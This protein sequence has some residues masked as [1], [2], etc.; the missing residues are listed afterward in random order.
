[1]NKLILKVLILLCLVLWPR[2]SLKALEPG[3]LLYRTTDNGKMYGYS[4][5]S[6]L[7]IKN[8]FLTGI[9]PGHVGIYIGEENGEHFIVEA[10]AGGIVKTPAKYFVNESLKEE[11]LGA[12]LPKEADIIDRLKAVKLAKSLVG[13]SLNYDFNFYK[14]KGPGS[15][16]WTCVGLT[17]KIYESINKNNPHDWISLEYNPDNYGIN[18]TPDGFDKDSI[19]NSD[20]DCFSKEVEFSKI[21]R[22]QNLLLPLPEIIGFNSGLEY[23]GERYIF[24][25]YTQFVQPTLKD[26]LVNINVSSNFE[27]DKIRG[28]TPIAKLLLRW[29][30]INNPV[31]TIKNTANKISSFFKKTTALVFNS[32]DNNLIIT[33]FDNQNKDNKISDNQGIVSTVKINTADN[34][35]DKQA[36]TLNQKIDSTEIKKP[37]AQTIKITTSENKQKEIDSVSLETDQSLKNINENFNNDASYSLESNLNDKNYILKSESIVKIN[38]SL[39]AL[40]NNISN[41]LRNVAVNENIEYKPNQTSISKILTGLEPSNTALIS[42]NN[43]EQQTSSFIPMALISKIYATD[44]NDFIELYNPL[45]YDFDLAE[46]SFRLEKSKTAEDPSLMMRIGNLNDGF[47]PGGTIIKSKGYYLIVRDDASDY[48]LSKADAIATR[49]EFSWT[50]SGYIIY[51]GKGAISSSSDEDILDAVGFGAAKYFQGSQPAPSILDNY[52]LDRVSNLN[53]NFL[54]FKLSAIADPNVSW[55]DSS[56]FSNNNN[57]NNPNNNQDNEQENQNNGED[58]SD[59]PA[60]FIAFSDPNPFLSSDI[61]YFRNFSECYG[62]NTYSVGRFDCGLEFGRNY[63]DWL[64]SLAEEI[65]INSF[66]L[67]FFYR[68]SKHFTDGPKLS[69]TLKNDTGQTLN[70]QLFESMLQIEGLPNSAWRYYEADLMPDNNWHHFVLT[71]NKEQNYWAVYIDGLERYR[72]SFIETLP[73][74]LYVLKIEGDVGSVG[75]DEFA[76]WRKPL[77]ILEINEYFSAQAPLF[78]SFVRSPQLPAELKYFWNFNEGHIFVNDGGGQVAIDQVNGLVLNLPENSWIWRGSENTGIINRWGDDL[79]VNFP[80]PL[81]RQDFSLSFWW[82]SGE[83][84]FG[85]RTLILLKNDDSHS[86]GI[87]PAH[88][89][90]SF[91]FNDQYGIFSEGDEVDLPHDENWH[92]FAL[93]YDS[94]RYLLKLYINGE[95]R[96]Q[97]PF[98]WIKEDNLPSSL[99][100]QSQLNN[101]GLDDIAVWEGTLTPGQVKKIFEET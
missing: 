52:F 50:G 11:F 44:S 13:L 32:Q 83:P 56:D 18:I 58:N 81:S 62:E 90:L 75:F 96:K 98:F 4:S 73:D 93:T 40:T 92:H 12:K 51:L 101:I 27:A 61:V 10:L 57:N 15:G 36:E 8:G 39:S 16:D 38:S 23:Q 91:F 55:D 14:Q 46:A 22:R 94:Y 97:L 21:A 66:S 49:N 41:Q 72:H 6:L 59:V 65:D 7:E 48:Y 53:D 26:T 69:L 78:P 5:D 35:F 37:I 42:N 64:I 54:D 60:D 33:E 28:K 9:N 86:L 70:L 67:G 87:A 76:I 71:V 3:A 25:P 34:N 82:R 20:G 79:E 17:E 77:S 19:F 89:R 80:S 74:N 99:S 100:I 43:S 45:D 84:P 1:M 31:S 24:L 68:N 95:E 88:N 29:S 63:P 2:N 30:L 47:Y 85:G